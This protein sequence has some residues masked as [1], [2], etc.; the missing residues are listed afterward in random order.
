MAGVVER[1]WL[2]LCGTDSSQ[3]VQCYWE[4]F[5]DLALVAAAASLPEVLRKEDHPWLEFSFLYLSIINGWYLYVHHF[6][7]RFKEASRLHWCLVWI[8]CLAMMWGVVNA[9]DQYQNFNLAMIFQRL[10]VFVMLARVACYVS[11][12]APICALLCFFISDAILCYTL[13]GAD[14]EAT[15]YLWGFAAVMEWLVDFFLAISLSG[16]LQI[17]Y[18]LQDTVDHFWAVV[19]APLGAI[20]VAAFTKNNN[21]D[22]DNYS[23]L[24]LASSV[25]LLTLFG[26]LYYGL[27]EAAYSNAMEQSSHVYRALLLMLLKLL[28]LALWSVGGCLSV[29]LLDNDGNLYISNLLGW[30]VG[31]SLILFL[32][33]RVFAGRPH[34]WLEVL[35]ILATWATYF[36]A[37]TLPPTSPMVQLSVYVVLVSILNILESWAS[38]VETTSTSRQQEEGNSG[39]EEEP[40][41][42]PATRTISRTEEP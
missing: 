20:A 2:H 18:R 22:N 10:A 6:A 30:S 27:K 9:V 25:L 21:N 8:Y 31:G 29:L 12:A 34:D 1:C 26:L 23:I 16:N 33:L 39:G 14:D 42:L 5:L 17:A 37:S 13:A 11:R 35:W 24:F 15:V 28:G 36:F 7:S 40:L 4:L 19:L 41:L 3:A 32:L 38:L